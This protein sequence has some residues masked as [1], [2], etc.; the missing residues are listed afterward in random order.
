MQLNIIS[1]ITCFENYKTLD[2]QIR[3]D[4]ICTFLGPL[5]TENVCSGDSG[6]PLMVSTY[7]TEFY[8]LRVTLSF[9]YDFDFRLIKREDLSMLV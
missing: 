6:S 5:G 9:M 4:M 2:I 8:I 1:N 7:Y 3:G